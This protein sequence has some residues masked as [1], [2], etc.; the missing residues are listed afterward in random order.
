MR[1]DREKQSGRFCFCLAFVGVRFRS[2]E[3]MPAGAFEEIQMN[4]VLPSA[5]LPSSTLDIP[6]CSPPRTSDN[7]SPPTAHPRAPLPPPSSAS[8]TFFFSPPSTRSTAYPRRRD[9]NFPLPP[10]LLRWNFHL[11]RPISG[12]GL[13]SRLHGCLSHPQTHHPR[14]RRCRV[15]GRYTWAGCPSARAFWSTD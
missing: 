7:S 12:P 11:R 6:T 10:L 14:L 15:G 13:R 1:Q 2:R 4:A 5:C 8:Q 9:T 3:V